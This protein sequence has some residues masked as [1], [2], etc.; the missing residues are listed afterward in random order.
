MIADIR[1]DMRWT[2]DHGDEALAVFDS[3]RQAV[4]TTTELQRRFPKEA[5]AHPT[6]PLAVGICPSRRRT[7]A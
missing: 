1:G 3:P 7:P 6:L 2:A 4:R 5:V